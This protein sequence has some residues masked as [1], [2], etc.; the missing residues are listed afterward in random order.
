MTIKRRN[1]AKLQRMINR[2]VKASNAYH[3]AQAE[4][5]DWCRDR[6]GYEPGDIDADQIIDGVLGG[7]GNCH[8]MTAEEFDDIMMRR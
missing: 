8:G 3:D 4:L 2:T 7:S 6:Y 5:N 1:M